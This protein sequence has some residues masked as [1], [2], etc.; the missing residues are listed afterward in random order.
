M[1]LCVFKERFCDSIVMLWKLP[2]M[3]CG[4][5]VT[6]CSLNKFILV[7]G[8]HGTIAG[9]GKGRLLGYMLLDC[10]LNTSLSSSK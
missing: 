9:I 10:S 3:D 7:I 8:S 1:S 6:L 5:W 4:D 2:E